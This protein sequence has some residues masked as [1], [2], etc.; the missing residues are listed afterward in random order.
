MLYAPLPKT[1]A[2]HCTA[3]LI[4]ALI[5]A[6]ITAFA[7]VETLTATPR[8]PTACAMAHAEKIGVKKVFAL[9]QRVSAR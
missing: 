9:I 3:V 7:R 6:L 2:T 4:R 8:L 1:L 5:Q